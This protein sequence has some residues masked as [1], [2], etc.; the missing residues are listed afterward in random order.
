MHVKTDCYVSFKLYF[1]DD[2]AKLMNWLTAEL[3]CDRSQS[4]RDRWTT[5]DDMYK[6]ETTQESIQPDSV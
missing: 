2:N 6:D 1:N 4:S 3:L 5:G